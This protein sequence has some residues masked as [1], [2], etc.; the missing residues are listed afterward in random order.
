VKCPVPEPQPDPPKVHIEVWDTFFSN[1]IPR[2]PLSY[3]IHPE[4]VSEVL[5]AKR[6]ELQKREGLNYRYKD[7]AFAY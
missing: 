4:F 1:T 7:F 2:K 5:H 3:T 6:M